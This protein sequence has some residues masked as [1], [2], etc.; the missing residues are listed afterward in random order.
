ME[1]LLVW[2][3]LLWWLLLLGRALVQGR[4]FNVR[5]RDGLLRTGLV[6]RD[7]VGVGFLERRLLRKRMGLGRRERVDKR[8]PNRTVHLWH[9]N[10]SIRDERVARGWETN[11][12]SQRVKRYSGSRDDGSGG[13]EHVITAIRRNR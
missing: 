8:L 5:H 13:R 6:H 10:W 11:N 7:R 2:R 12:G 9:L 1:S 3:L 4:G